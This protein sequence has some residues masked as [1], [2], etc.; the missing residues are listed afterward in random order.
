[1]KNNNKKVSITLAK[2]S[3]KASRMRNIFILITIILSVGLLAGL[4]FSSDAYDTEYKR[5][6]A[7]GSQVIYQDVSTDQIEPLEND[8]KIELATAI[9][10][11]KSFEANDYILIPYYIEDTTLPMAGVT[12]AEGKYPILANEVLVDK[13]LMGYLGKDAK[14]GEEISVSYLDGTIEVYKISGFMESEKKINV[15]PLYFSKEYADYG[16]QL[17]EIPYE[18]A[19]QIVGAVNMSKET[20][21]EEIHN[22]GVL[23]GV[24][25][26]NINENNRFADSLSYDDNQLGMTIMVGLAILLVSVIVIYSIFYIS[27]AERTRQFGQLRTIGMTRKQIRKMVCYE[28]TILS[29]MGSAIG[30]LIGAIFA[31]TIK[32]K[33]FDLVHF[34]V[35]AIC[36]FIA[37]YIT[38]QVSIAKP[39][40]IAAN[41]APME[42]IKQSGYETKRKVSNKLHRKLSPLSL[43][44]IATNGN[45]KKS[46]L[47]MLSLCLAGIIFM[48]SST[49]VTSMSEEKFAR[50]GWMEY[51]EFVFQLS[52]N[53]AQVNEYGYTGV[54]Q[55]N[56][57]SDSFVQELDKIDGVQNVM[58]KGNLDVT[59][60]YNGEKSEDL[61]AGIS[62]DELELLRKY[63]SNESMNYETMMKNKEIY[64]VNNDVMKEI[65]GYKFKVGDTVD[66][67]WFN[68]GSYVEDSFLIA[69]EIDK[70]IYN[71]MEAFP[72]IYNTGWFIGASDMIKSM[73]IPEFN[74]NNVVVVACNDYKADGSAI[75]AQFIGMEENNAS[76]TLSTLSK[77]LEASK[78]DY[79]MIKV[80]IMAIAFFVIVFSLIN[81]T[82]TLITNVVARKREF[83][84]FRTLGMTQKQVGRMIQGEGLYLACINI[85]S[86]TI[87]GSFHSYLMV[88]LMQKQGIKYLDYQFPWMYLGGYI[89]IVLV[90]P[91]VIS[92]VSIKN[93]GKKSLMERMRECD[94]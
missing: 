44:L 4:A 59:Y 47:T 10:R 93:I 77:T 87:V 55:N 33:G 21:L 50:Q 3:L 17:R 63:S 42:A 45:R 74:L 72:L 51:G 39:A 70:K 13:Q 79:A 28:G 27:I 90:I 14:I 20:F 68:G 66:L 30:I 36:I 58:V 88:V 12:I 80:M 31:Y 43:S 46:V 48:S 6:L 9:K 37:D 81:L 76:V 73:M 24:A 82:N 26:K 62:K 49:F 92:Q 52:N 91:M 1:M 38:V 69:G 8:E 71:D 84:C 35:I 57:L 67:R 23:Y 15:F 5:S 22:I 78:S 75:E 65:Y 18:V 53:A 60:S 19:A 41:I 29:L 85:I 32:A 2:Q 40:K 89:V 7:N 56:P 64:I 25:K 86:T 83:A 94:Y 61:I 11:G 16:S 54:K 34:L